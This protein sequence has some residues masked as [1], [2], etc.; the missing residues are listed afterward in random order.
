MLTKS[1]DEHRKRRVERWEFGLERSNDLLNDIMNAHRTWKILDSV[2]L[3]PSLSSGGSNF[4]KL[5]LSSL[6]LLL[7][8]HRLLLLLLQL[9]VLLILLLLLLLLMLLLL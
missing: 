8:L 1:F 9:L 3:K 2:E 6:A 4:I 5:C 7:S